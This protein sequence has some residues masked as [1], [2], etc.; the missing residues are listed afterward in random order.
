MVK[1]IRSAQ[2]QPEWQKVLELL[3]SEPVQH[4]MIAAAAKGLPPISA[5]GRIL[6][7]RFPDSTTSNAAR[8]F[9]GVCIAGV[10]AEAGYEVAQSRAR[11]SDA[12][13][14]NSGATY[15]LARAA[16]PGRGEDQD[17]ALERMISALTRPQ[18]QR[19]LAALRARFPDMF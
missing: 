17:D 12:G 4:D 3:S 14:F 1:A 7:E 16:E 13:P 8:Q 18:A 10:M 6:S 2:R 9:I 11:V 19:A 15:R 5:V